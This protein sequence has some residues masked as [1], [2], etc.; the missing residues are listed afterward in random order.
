[1]ALHVHTFAQPFLKDVPPLFS[2]ELG[3]VFLIPGV[4]IRNGN[5]VKFEFSYPDYDKNIQFSLG[6]L[7]TLKQKE[8][9]TTT[10][11]GHANELNVG[12]ITIDI[13]PSKVK[14]PDRTAGRFGEVIVS[15]DMID[16]YRER[17]E[18]LGIKSETEMALPGRLARII[19]GMPDGNS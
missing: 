3:E 10:V 12:D 17:R 9:K 4:K 1:L 13:R 6:E 5:K 16:F 2:F 7:S 15:R 14:R 11:T 18:L 19:G 8:E